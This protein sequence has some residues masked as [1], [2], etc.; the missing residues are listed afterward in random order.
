[1]LGNHHNLYVYPTVVCHDIPE[2]CLIARRATCYNI[3]AS[4]LIGNHEK[5]FVTTGASLPL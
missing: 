4:M 1:M 2:K 3:A 5:M